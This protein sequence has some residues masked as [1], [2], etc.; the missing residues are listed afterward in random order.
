MAVT[1]YVK[2]VAARP[3]KDSGTYGFPASSPQSP[4]APAAPFA[5]P[6]APTA[7]GAGGMNRAKAQQQSYRG[8]S[9][10]ERRR[11]EAM[12]RERNKGKVDAD[13]EVEIRAINAEKAGLNTR[14]QE[15]TSKYAQLQQKISQ[16][17]EIRDLARKQIGL[18]TQDPA[19]ILRDDESKLRQ[20]Q[21]LLQ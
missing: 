5:A 12:E 14:L 15:G 19:Q 13:A 1:R 20:I 16:L 17:E 3:R 11:Q 7:P 18:T 6:V 9:P 21:Q 4:A 10:T 8:I 2:K